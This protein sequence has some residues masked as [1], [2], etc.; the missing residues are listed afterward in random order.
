MRS[1]VPRIINRNIKSLNG[2][3]KWM[4]LTR[5]RQSAQKYFLPCSTAAFLHYHRRG[6]R[7]EEVLT[8]SKTRCCV[9]LS[10]VVA[11]LVVPFAF[12]IFWAWPWHLTLGVASAG[13]TARTPID[14]TSGACLIG[15]C[16][17]FA[18]TS[19]KLNNLSVAKAEVCTLFLI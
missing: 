13:S 12:D 7:R 3:K 2:W 5:R 16:S 15:F 11:Q 17:I 8:L 4:S 10:S 19:L 18:L 9:S 1:T 6:E 14:S